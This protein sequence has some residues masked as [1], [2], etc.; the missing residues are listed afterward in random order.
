MTA[1]VLFSISALFLKK[2]RKIVSEK[3]HLCPPVLEY[4]HQLLSFSDVLPKCYPRWIEFYG[5]KS[6]GILKQHKVPKQPVRNIG[7]T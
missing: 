4:L 5:V 1:S 3:L 7:N 6:N 2:F